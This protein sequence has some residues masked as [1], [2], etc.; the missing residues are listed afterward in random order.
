MGWSPR[1]GVSL[2]KYVTGEDEGSDEVLDAALYDGCDIAER[3]LG[4]LKLGEK[5][6]W[7]KL[8]SNEFECFTLFGMCLTQE[9]KE[10]A[11]EHNNNERNVGWV[12]GLV[13]G[14]KPKF[15]L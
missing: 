12:F 10:I 7:L 14:L 6:E 13:E 2:E 15:V 9:R 11:K 5:K 4:G 8:K 1:S 3:D